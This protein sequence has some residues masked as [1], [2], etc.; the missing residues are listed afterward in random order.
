[1]KNTK[2]NRKKVRDYIKHFIL[3]HVK[4]NDINDISTNDLTLYIKNHPIN[5]WL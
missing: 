1:M 3:D 4:T 2:K 5:D